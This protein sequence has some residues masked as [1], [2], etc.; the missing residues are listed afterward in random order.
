MRVE[1]VIDSL[2]EKLIKYQA[3]DC[4]ILPKGDRYHILCRANQT[5]TH[6]ANYPWQE[7]LQMIAYLKYEANMA[8]SEHRRPQS[9]ALHLQKRNMQIN[10]RFSSVGDFRGA[11]S[12]VIRLIYPLDSQ[13][14]RMLNFKQW[15]Q[16]SQMTKGQGLILFA[17][18]MGSGKTTTMYHL[19]KKNCQNQVVLS[20]EDPVEIQEE[21]FIQLQV[22]P[23]AKM[24]YR[25]EERSVGKEC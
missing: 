15:D 2:L 25:S 4:Y 14:Y 5:M 16:L 9:G 23:S 17:G 19:V 22:N 7:G 3:T 13:E 10:L 20:I 1:S 11:E 18:P 8:V 21:D 6:L 12:L 24:S